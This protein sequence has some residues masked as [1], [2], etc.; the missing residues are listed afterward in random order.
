MTIAG[1]DSAGGAGVHADL[2]TF[3]ALGLHGATAV[4]ALTAQNTRGIDG[5]HLVPAEFVV[6]QVESVLADL[7]V[8]AV[9]TGFLGATSVVEAVGRLA[10]HARLGQL[11]VDPVLVRADGT[12]MFTPEVADA[13][14]RSLVPFATVLTPNRVEAGILTG[15]DVATLADMERAAAD[16]ARLGPQLVVVKGGDAVDEDVESIDVVAD[17]SGAVERLAMPMV[18]TPND[19]G[20]GCTFA[21][22]T[23][24]RLALGDS[25]LEAVRAAKS[26]VYEALLGSAEWRVGAGHGPLDQYGWDT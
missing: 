11:V 20:S 8:R 3:A 1:M 21:A 14:R 10:A 22:A 26:F 19:H 17:P 5:V 25:P 2:R 13:Y 16:L 23:T 9:K 4:A 15:R 24:A 18:D 6:A 12:P 7:D